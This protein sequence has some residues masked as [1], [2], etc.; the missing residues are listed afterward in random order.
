MLGWMLNRGAHASHAAD[1]DTTEFDPPDTPAPVF[2][3]RALKSAIFG[4]PTPETQDSSSRRGREIRKSRALPLQLSTPQTKSAG[5]LVTPGTGNRQRKRVSFDRDAPAATKA[6]DAASTHAK[7]QTPVVEKNKTNGSAK[8]PEPFHDSDDDWDDDID[9]QDCAND[10]TTDLAEPRSQSGQYWKQ[11]LE[12][13][14]TEARNEMA[15][16]LKHQQLTK[17][18]AQQKDA[19]AVQLAE[20]LAEQKEKLV[21]E[22]DEKDCEIQRLKSEHATYR[23]NNL[24]ETNAAADAIRP[25]LTFL[26]AQLDAAQLALAALQ[27]DKENSSSS[28]VQESRA[29]VQ[30]A[31]KE[32]ER[33]YHRM[34]REHD[35]Y[36][37]SSKKSV[38]SC[39]KGILDCVAF[40]KG[41][42]EGPEPP[43]NMFRASPYEKSE[44]RESSS[45]QVREL[46]AQLQQAMAENEDKNQEIRRLKNSSSLQGQDV[47]AQMQQAATE[48]EE[49]SLEIRR[50][51][52]EFEAYR[53]ETEKREADKAVVILKLSEKWKRTRC[54]L[55][56][57][58]AHK[59]HQGRYDKQLKKS[60]L[61]KR[62][63]GGLLGMQRDFKNKK[64]SSLDREVASDDDMLQGQDVQAF[65]EDYYGSAE[66]VKQRML[67]K[68]AENAQYGGQP[69]VARRPRKRAIF[70]D[71]WSRGPKTQGVMTT[72]R[73]APARATSRHNEAQVSDEEEQVDLL[74]DRFT[75]LGGDGGHNRGGKASKLPPER[76]AAALA[77]IQQER[78]ESGKQWWQKTTDK[79]NLY[80]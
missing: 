30:Q 68:G 55:L 13:Y 79:E 42:A 1:Q 71:Q 26:M 62:A 47:R 73:S 33:L 36:R 23:A 12:R 24:Q 22:K 40:V 56:R 45:S 80:S 34:L 72:G 46:K 75:Q 9:D 51:Q 41:L 39:A 50:L 29:Q 6:K 19:E 18:F 16:L 17:S 8:P 52:S 7:K 64:H 35:K 43:F 14:R 69:S 15:K 63:S 61:P 2:A 60:V 11:E 32:S 74:R 4:T 3:A 10:V 38:G 65:R 31:I 21:K 78:A 20:R 76:R 37:C 77:R 70:E 54:E 44:K 49:K 59:P 25:A 57:L 53:S 67:A 66:D 27:A 48:T 28:Q 58:K 5:I